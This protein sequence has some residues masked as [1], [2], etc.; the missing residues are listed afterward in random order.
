MSKDDLSS[1]TILDI[2]KT[3]LPDGTIRDTTGWD[4]VC[5]WPPDLFAAVATIT[6]R[7]G[8]YSERIFTAYWDKAEFQLTKEW[9]E[10]IRKAGEEWASQATP[11]KLVQELWSELIKQHR[12]ARI[13]DA[14]DKS[15]PW[16][17]IVFHLLAI[18]D[19]ASGGVGFPPAGSNRAIQYAVYKDYIFWE[20]KSENDRDAIGGEFLPYLPHSICIRVPPT[21]LCVQ[22]KTNTPGV[23]CTLRSLT[24]N[25][26]LLPSVAHVSTSWQISNKPYDE[27]VPFNVLVVP[28]PFSIPGKSFI[29][30]TDSTARAFRLDPNTWMRGATEEEFAEEFICGLL[31]SAE[32]EL[33]PVHAVVLPETALTLKFADKVAEILLKKSNLDLFITGVVAG[34]QNVAR[35]LAATYRFVN[36]ERIHS[37]FQSKHHRWCLDGD[38]ICRYHL[39]HVMDPHARWWEQIDVRYR[40]C[41]VTVFRPGATVSVLVCEDLARYDP[42]L[43]VMNAIGPN[44]VVAL[45]MDGPQLEHRWPGRYATVLAD[46]PG[47]AVLTV[48]SLGMVSRSAMPGDPENREIALWKESAGRA[49]PLRL[50]KGDHALLLTLTSR[51]VEQFTL[52]GRGD[53]GGTVHFGLGAA[54][55]IRHPAPP[56]WLGRIPRVELDF[57]NV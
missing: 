8:L 41:Y 10:K 4:Q 17:S 3:V 50:P 44:L 21:V 46:D 5:D 12:K 28:F 37:S 9:I 51:F 16:K 39:G 1:M 36:K 6:E 7:S 11:P 35:N 19:Q 45:L 22:P 55:G 49:R 56:Q 15:L 14:S 34:D 43:T 54:H 29:G 48:T 31:K 20:K 18:A 26:A 53:G 27:L 13:D 25:L 23:G 2:I 47:S 42:V 33:E 38:Q 24:H 57:E 30:R 40:S 32:Q 52:D